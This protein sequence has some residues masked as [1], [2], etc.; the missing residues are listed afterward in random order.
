MLEAG[1]IRATLDPR[2]L[3]TPGAIVRESRLSPAMLGAWLVEWQIDLVAGDSGTRAAASVLS[4]LLDKLARI[5][6]V[7]DVIRIDLTLPGAGDGLPAYR[8]TVT[9]QVTQ[10]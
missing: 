7:D 8:A 5:L 1:G 3:N 10:D 4:A 6:P 2:D 9:S